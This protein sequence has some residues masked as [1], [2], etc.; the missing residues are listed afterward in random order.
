[1]VEIMY[2]DPLTPKVSTSMVAENP[3]VRPF[4]MGKKGQTTARGG[5]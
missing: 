3:S 5:A 1:M 4:N 2:Q